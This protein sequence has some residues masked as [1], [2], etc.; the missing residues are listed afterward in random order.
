[1]NFMIVPGMFVWSIFLISVC[2][3]IVLKDLLISNAIV[4]VRAGEPFG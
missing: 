3:L 2:M 4:I 1:M